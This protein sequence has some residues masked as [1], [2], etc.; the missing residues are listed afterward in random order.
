MAAAARPAGPVSVL[1]D[2]L[3]VAAGSSRLLRGPSI[4]LGLLTLALVGPGVVS[5]LWVLSWSGSVDLFSVAEVDAANEAI[6]RSVWL[7]FLAAVGLAAVSIEGGAIGAM[8]IAG[9]VTGRAVDLR[10]AVE[11]SRRVFWR[12]VRVALMVGVL[13]FI[14]SAAWRA[15]TNAPPV[16]DN[17]PNVSIEPIPGAI[18][19]LPFI[20]ST[21]AIVVGDDGARAA[22]RRSAGLVRRRVRLAIA[23]AAFALMSGVIESLALGSGLDL[24]VRVTEV[25]HLDVTTGGASLFLA[26]GLALAI[27]T[28][29]GSLVFTVSALVSAPQVV[30]WDRLGLP[31][32]GLPAAEPVPPAVE[33]VA[34]PVSGS[35]VDPATDPAEPVAEPSAEPAVRPSRSPSRRPSPR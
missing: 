32:G 19:S 12:L 14:A 5:E 30:A 6:G 25:L 2:G 13:E 8:L 29:V 21:V 31:T 18:V 26:M 34:E 17:V 24:I 35:V 23:L 9:R 33:R 3:T 4:Y 22:L 15:A 11:R 16:L 27:V 1:G 20:Y 28:A 7:I 10:L